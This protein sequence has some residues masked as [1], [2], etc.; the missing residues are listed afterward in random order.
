VIETLCPFCGTSA[1]V[2][3]DAFGAIGHWQCRRCGQAWDARRLAT[4]AEY[5]AWVAA[6]DERKTDSLD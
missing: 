4:V 1:A 3:H 2:A 5:A 6:H